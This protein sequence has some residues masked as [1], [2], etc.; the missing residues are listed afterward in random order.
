M[1][2]GGTVTVAQ[3]NQGNRV[4]V[5]RNWQVITARCSSPPKRRISGEMCSEGVAELA[6]NSPSKPATFR[7]VFGAFECGKAR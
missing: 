1:L 3:R 6:I 4:G 5:V 2:K 7:D